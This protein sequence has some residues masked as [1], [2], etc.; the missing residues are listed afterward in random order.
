MALAPLSHEPRMQRKLPAATSPAHQPLL[1][2]PDRVR[3]VAH[4]QH[5]GCM[6][7]ALLSASGP[8]A[9]HQDCPSLVLPP[10]VD[11]S[12][13]IRQD[14][15][16]TLWIA[17]AHA[18]IVASGPARRPSSENRERYWT[19]QAVRSRRACSSSSMRSVS[20]SAASSSRRAPF[21]SPT[22][23]RRW[24]SWICASRLDEVRASSAKSA[25]H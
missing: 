17:A 20:S 14:E 16:I 21:T 13:V 1:P 9:R 15:S 11:D 18:R 8:S 10:P 5:F 22:A 4:P 25:C 12:Q 24:P 2:F 6:H 7:E 3:W 19:G 23:S